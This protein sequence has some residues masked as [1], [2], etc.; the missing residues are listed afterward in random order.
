MARITRKDLKTDKFALEVEHTV[1]FFEEHRSEIVRYGAIAVAVVLV[2]L[3]VYFYMRHQGN[4]RDRALADALA[5]LDVPLSPQT[6]SAGRSF[7]NADAREQEASRAFADVA[8]KYSGSDQGMVAE[9]TL[10]SLAADQGRL[11]EAEK[12]YLLVAGSGNKPYASLAKLALGD[13]YTSQR[14][15]AEA[16]KVLREV[17]AN[18]T[19]FVSKEEATI[20]LARAIGST[21]PDEARKLLEPLRTSRSAVAQAAIQAIGEIGRK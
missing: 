20:A 14:R 10:A 1:D 6:N 4:V 17:V 8:A 5:V 18:P 11:A 21:K 13:L 2:V 19:I 7:P 12:R 15:S 3:A 16:E 9:Y